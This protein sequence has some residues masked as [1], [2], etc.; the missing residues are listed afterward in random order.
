MD[1]AQIP[2]DDAE[3]AGEL[4]AGITVMTMDTELLFNY[5][6]CILC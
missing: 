3:S 5:I 6:R 4:G 1:H 2:V